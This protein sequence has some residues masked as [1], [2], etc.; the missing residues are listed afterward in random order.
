MA[1]LRFDVSA[2]SSGPTRLSAD[3]IQSIAGQLD[4][5]RADFLAS[6]RDDADPAGFFGLPEQQLAAYLRD[7]QQ[8]PLGRIFHVANGL[9]HHFDA[10]VVLGLDDVT[11]G[12]RALR[13]A[14]CD[15]YHNERSRAARG[16][17]PRMYF[18]GDA[19]DNDAAASLIERILEGGYGDTPAERRWAIVVV[20]RSGE[21]LPTAVALRQFLA[22]L[23]M[24][25]GAEA[26][27]W[28]GRLVIPITGGDGRLRL[29]ATEMGCEEVYT[30]PAGLPSGFDVL[31]PISLMPAA[32]LGLDCIKLLEGA[33]VMNEHFRAAE[34]ADNM[35][36]Q[37]AAVQL[38]CGDAGARPRSQAI[39]WS[40]ALRTVARWC[41]SIGDHGND[42][43][44]H[45]PS[46]A[47]CETYRGSGIHHI[48]VDSD[49]HDV[50]GVGRLGVGNSLRDQDGLNAIADQTL[51]ELMQSAAGNHRDRSAQSGE[52]TTITTLPTIDTFVLGQLFQMCMISAHLQR[53]FIGEPSSPGPD[54]GSA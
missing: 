31:S 27:Q 41:Q 35:A 14:C 19:F 11:L 54:S 1:S 36:I 50:L 12:A 30:I 42:H 32:M 4:R 44:G 9:H 37:H 45:P 43:G 18:G 8:S 24:S 23:E 6:A 39:V 34:P 51:T 33:A 17:K 5:T 15:P 21:S 29:L 40:E 25:L 38:A 20:D 16:S 10:V 2:A 53:Q 13:D 3:R 22:A 46:P 48:M 47:A 49:R 28:L 7:R 26:A 52:L